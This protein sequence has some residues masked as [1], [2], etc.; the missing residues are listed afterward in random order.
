LPRDN[1]LRALNRAVL[2]GL[3][4]LGVF[5][6]R[7]SPVRDTLDLAVENVLTDGSHAVVHE[8]QV[9]NLTGILGSGCRVQG[10]RV[11]I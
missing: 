5:L 3:R 4:G 2:G 8:V 6:W 9:M 11:R 7:G 10:L 1:R